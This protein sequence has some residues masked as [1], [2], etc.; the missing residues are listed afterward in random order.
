MEAN[1][2]RSNLKEFA[3]SVRRFV[4]MFVGSLIP[5]VY[6]MWLREEA[7]RREHAERIAERQRLEQQQ[8]L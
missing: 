2:Q 8:Q 3:L 7:I 5:F 4:L 6:D 1:E